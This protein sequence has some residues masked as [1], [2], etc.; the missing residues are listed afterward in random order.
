MR[1][2]ND[3]ELANSHNNT[4]IENNQSTV[5]TLISQVLGVPENLITD[6]LEY[7]SIMEWD[8]LGHIS[9]LLALEKCYGL[10]ILPEDRT[11][12]TSVGA[13]KKYFSPDS[14][15]A[16]KNGFNSE[17]IESSNKTLYRGLN[18]IAFDKTRISS[19]D[20]K[21]GHLHYRGY[22]I[23]DLVEQSHFEETAYLLLYGKMPT[24]KQLEDFDRELKSS[25]KIPPAMLDIIRKLD[26]AHPIEVLRTVI[27]AMAMYDEERNSTMFFKRRSIRLIAQIPTIIA[28]HLKLRSGQ[29]IIEPSAT[30]SHADNFLYMLHGTPPTKRVSSV[31]E[32][33]LILH[34]DHGSNASA[35]AARVVASTNSDLY[36]SLTAAIATFA[37]ELHGGAIE[38]VIGMIKEIGRPELAAAY[39]E[40]QHAARKPVMGFGHRVYQTEDPRA[41]HLRE[42][43][44]NLSR[45]RGEPLWF[46]IL[47]AVV[48]AM[49]SYIGKGIDVNV[50]FYA[51]VIYHLLS[52]PDDLFI[53]VFAAGRL[54]G[55]IAQVQE[56][57]DNN[58]LI[59]PLLTY[60]GEKDLSY[61]PINKR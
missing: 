11:L 38:K 23:H 52:I 41:R 47:E 37:G 9:L 12:L 44:Y 49:K 15:K 42:I 60:T 39:V 24:A 14:S 48:G 55:W 20:G 7:Q 50:D 36:S 19:I 4:Q 30:L 43:A 33:I 5:E 3:V 25:R 61:V 10:E 26:Q 57:Y 22:S 2:Q 21:N 1:T 8:S 6:Q 28:A 45:E 17:V 58:I 40:R 51:S 32:K 35:F 18:G 16:V 31:F 46:D 29:T 59:R 34:A 53:S 56:Q 27:S 54:P 13:I